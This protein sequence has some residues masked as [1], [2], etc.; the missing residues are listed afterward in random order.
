MVIRD[1]PDCPGCTVRVVGGEGGCGCVLWFFISKLPIY[2]ANHRARRALMF[3]RVLD[4]I[5]LIGCQDSVR[6][7]TIGWVRC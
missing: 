2:Q 6:S 3:G 7:N 1:P 4:G 5:S